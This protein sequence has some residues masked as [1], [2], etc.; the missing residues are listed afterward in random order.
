MTSIDIL[1]KRHGDKDRSTPV[2]A[3][4]FADSQLPLSEEGKRA[5]RAFGE[6]HI[7]RD[8]DLIVA[9]SGTYFRVKQTRDENLLGAGY[10][11]NNENKVI[12]VERSDLSLGRYNFAHPSMPPVKPL[13]RY[14]DTM[15][16][17]FWQEQP[18]DAPTMSKYAASFCD[19]LLQGVWL[20]DNAD[21]GPDAKA[22]LKIDTHSPILDAGAYAVSETQSLTLPPFKMG[23]FFTG[24][25]R[26]IHGGGDELPGEYFDF[27]IKGESHRLNYGQVGQM[28][29]QCTHG[30]QPLL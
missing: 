16:T 29:Y 10:E 17:T 30:E 13:D 5:E 2:V 18:G 7:A 26:R 19:A 25:F 14:V 3:S 21:L 24:T 28:R 6:K 1:A 23:E 20:V 9:I 12:V 4:S 8:Y 27:N 22:L 15:L 11:P